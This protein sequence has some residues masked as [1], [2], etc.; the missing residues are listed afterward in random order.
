MSKLFQILGFLVLFA[1][2]ALAQEKNFHDLRGMEDSTGTTHLFYRVMDSESRFVYTNHIYHFNTEDKTERLLFEEQYFENPRDTLPFDFVGVSDFH[3]LENDLNKVIYLQIN[4]FDHPVG[5]YSSI[6]QKLIDWDGD[7]IA[8]GVHDGQV[9]GNAIG[10]PSKLS[11]R[12]IINYLFGNEVFQ[13]GTNI[14]TTLT[15]YDAAEDFE[16]ALHI[17]ADWSETE[18]LVAHRND[19]LFILDANFEILT[20]VKSP[21]NYSFYDYSLVDFYFPSDSSTFYFRQRSTN[22]YL[23][24]PVYRGDMVNEEII[25]KE[26][27]PSRSQNGFN[28]Q[29]FNNGEVVYSDSTAV[30]FSSDRGDTFQKL[31]DMNEYVTGLYFNQQ[32]LLYILTKVHLY[33]YNFETEELIN[34]L[35]LPTSIEDSNVGMPSTISLHQNYP[36]PFNPSTNIQFALPA[37]SHVRLAVYDQLGRELQV[38]IDDYLPLGNHVAT[39]NANNYSSGIYYYVLDAVDLNERVIKKMTLIK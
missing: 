20:R 3:F 6:Y 31:I 9:I 34:L 30:L 32:Q 23:S 38:L 16:N 33:S 35:D 36:N 17:V 2:S 26:I 13:K 22:K 18:Q 10:I 28:I 1:T 5:P 4:Q 15:L 25:F 11:D 7:E 14:D 24:Y 8:Q 29:P 39:F 37:D 12:I 21:F 27:I 19:T